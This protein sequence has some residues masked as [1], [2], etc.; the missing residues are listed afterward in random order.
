[1]VGER[2][3][4]ACKSL[5][6]RKISAVVKEL[7]D[8]A[9]ATIALIENLQRENLNFI[10]EAEGYARLINDFGFTQEALAQRLGKANPPSPTS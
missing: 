1:M 10:E 5:G 8:N 7:S 6:M 4:L 9:V 3:Y 2:R